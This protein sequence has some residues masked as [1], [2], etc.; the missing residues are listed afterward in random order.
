MPPPPLLRIMKKV[1]VGC[2]PKLAVVPAHHQP[3]TTTGRPSHREVRLQVGEQHGEGVGGQRAHRR[4]PPLV[5]ARQHVVVQRK[6]LRQ[7]RFR[8]AVLGQGDERQ[9][10][11]NELGPVLRLQRLELL[12]DERAHGGGVDEQRAVGVLVVGGEVSVRG[13]LAETDR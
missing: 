8:H 10:G 7:L 1:D 11:A 12:D 3:A 9:R 6:N 2:F 13:P 4:H 5:H